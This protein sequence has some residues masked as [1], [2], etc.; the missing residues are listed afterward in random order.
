MT[1]LTASQRAELRRL[2]EALTM[3]ADIAECW[4]TVDGRKNIQL[5]CSESYKNARTVLSNLPTAA[6]ALLDRLGL[7]KASQR[8]PGA[9]QNCERCGCVFDKP[10]D[11]WQ[12]EARPNNCGDARCP[13]RAAR[14]AEK[15]PP[16]ASSPIPPLKGVQNARM[17]PAG[18][19]E[20][21]D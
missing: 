2:A 1:D 8:T 5:D 20:E 14:E 6:R 16:G 11:D 3:L 19:G 12:K 13:I 10:N 9:M 17:L 21:G 18:P 4:E 7:A 15:E